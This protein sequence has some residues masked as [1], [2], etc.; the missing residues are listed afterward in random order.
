MPGYELR[1]V[2]LVTPTVAGRKCENRW[3]IQHRPKGGK[4]ANVPPEWV[5][6]T[7]VQVAAPPEFASDDDAAAYAEKVQ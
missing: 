6:A 5:N 3:W 2:E 1:V 4:W 7:H